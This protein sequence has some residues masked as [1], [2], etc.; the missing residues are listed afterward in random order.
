[1]PTIL[2]RN[3]LNNQKS[4]LIP[5]HLPFAI[6]V[7]HFAALSTCCGW[8]SIRWVVVR[9]VTRSV[10]LGPSEMREDRERVA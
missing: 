7:M 1:M 3:R 2:A 8:C 10:V 6:C 9:W 4:N 5:K